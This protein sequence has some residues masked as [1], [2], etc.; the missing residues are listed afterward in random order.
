[1]TNHENKFSYSNNECYYINYN[2]HQLLNLIFN[3]MIK[4]TPL[5][6]VKTYDLIKNIQMTYSEKPKFHNFLHVVDIHY[7]LT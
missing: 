4:Y 3:I 1:M 5:S 6:N 7:I 2:N